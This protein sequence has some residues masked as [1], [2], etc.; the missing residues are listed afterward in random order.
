[1][2]PL[3][4]GNAL[5]AGR[6][7]INAAKFYRLAIE[8]MSDD[9]AHP[10]RPWALFQAGNSLR[11]DD[12]AEAAKFYDL[13]ISEFPNS[14]WTAAAKVEQAIATWSAAVSPEKLLEK[15]ASDPNSL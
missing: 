7:Y 5:Y 1:V 15:Y 14:P 9:K 12:K 11:F 3:E 13:L 10:D 2:H 8:R 4:V 6:D